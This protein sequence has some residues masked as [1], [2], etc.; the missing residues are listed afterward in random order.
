MALSHDKS[1]MMANLY[2][3]VDWLEMYSASL[4]V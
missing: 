4:G 3:R 1:V 2:S